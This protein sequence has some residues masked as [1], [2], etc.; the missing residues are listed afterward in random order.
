MVVACHCQNA[1]E[2][3]SQPSLQHIKTGL[4][5]QKVASSEYG[6]YHLFW[7]TTCPGSLVVALASALSGGQG[8]PVK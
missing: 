5:M 8:L 2:T 7:A 4:H 1:I 3:D 6:I